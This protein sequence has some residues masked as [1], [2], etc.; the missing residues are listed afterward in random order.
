MPY[1]D[2]L[3]FVAECKTFATLLFSHVTVP[4]GSVILPL[5]NCSLSFA[6]I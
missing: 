3:Q 1:Q 2:K 5:F 6:E 4:S